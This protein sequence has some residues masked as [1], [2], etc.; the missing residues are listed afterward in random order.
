MVLGGLRVGQLR[1]KGSFA[2]A[3]VIWWFSSVPTVVKL[4]WANDGVADIKN[5]YNMHVKDSCGV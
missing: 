2:V 1:K 4:N 3:T 5:V